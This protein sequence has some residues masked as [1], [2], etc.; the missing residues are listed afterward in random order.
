MAPND[1]GDDQSICIF[2]LMLFQSCL[3]GQQ[4]C[5]PRRKKNGLCGGWADWEEED[6]LGEKPGCVRTE[7]GCGMSK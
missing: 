2:P 7:K 5:A 1:G 3:K 6:V 4:G